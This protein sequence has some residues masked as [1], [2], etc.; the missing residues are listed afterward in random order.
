MGKHLLRPK[1][2]LSPVTQKLFRS[3]GSSGIVGEIKS[4]LKPV[5]EYSWGEVKIQD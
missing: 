1:V 2:V 5:T 3:E 4:Q